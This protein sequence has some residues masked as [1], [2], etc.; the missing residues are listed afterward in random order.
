MRLVENGVNGRSFSVESEHDFLDLANRVANETQMHDVRGGRYLRW[1]ADCG[2]ELWL[3][4]DSDNDLIGMA[5]HFSG[6]ASARVGLTSR[7]SRPND[8]AL[9][10]AFHGWA[11][12]FEGDPESGMYPFVFDSPDY[13]RH[14]ELELPC[15]ASV[16]V[17]AF[18]HEVSVFAS[19][20]EYD[21]SQEGEMKF[22][23]Q[24]FIP[25][26]MFSPEGE[27]TEPPEAYAI[28]TGHILRA[29]KRRN[30]MS[31]LSFVWVLVES[32]GATF[33]VVIDL[34]LMDNAPQPGGVLTGSFWLSGRVQQ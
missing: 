29:G 26:G 28:F 20:E 15:I 21:A 10:G 5:P 13:C 32:L 12:P 33:D 1:T 25:S 30:E 7:V 31:G 18:A 2:T 24:S 34:E 23:S 22:A 8:T 14:S 17:A 3:Q 9:D 6:E 16:Q 19:V 27:S 4:V 11:A